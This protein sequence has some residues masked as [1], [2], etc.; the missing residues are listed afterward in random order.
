MR[1][2]AIGLLTLG[3]AL[4]LWLYLSR[5]SLSID[6]TMLSL[7]IGLRSYAGLLRPL[8]SI[9]TA[10]PLFLWGV[11]L[12]ATLGGMSEY[13]L[14]VL[15][16]VAGL[17]VPVGVWRV[18]RR[19]WPEPAALAA[20]GLAAFAPTLVQY[21]VTMKP[22]VSDALFALVTIA[23]ALDVIERPAARA[24]WVRLALGGLLAILGSIPA[25]FVLAG[26]AAALVTAPSVR[27]SP[28]AMPRVG[29]CVLVWGAAFALVYLWLYR[30]AATSAYMQQFWVASFLIP[31]APV[32]GDSWA[33]PW[34]RPST[35]VRRRSQRS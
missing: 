18:A 32:A 27:R 15:P 24:T 33:S 22:Y 4:R 9:Q 28:Q 23:L 34:S 3:A 13:T 12:C 30:P 19:L 25:P 8:D 2:L 7:E 14:R 11:K 29:G 10:P 35:P 21:S 17:L 6:E 31:F 1:R 20:A 5:P 16:L 26:A